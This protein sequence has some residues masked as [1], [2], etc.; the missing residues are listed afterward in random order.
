VGLGLAWIFGEAVGEAVPVLTPGVI[1]SVL[2][3]AGGLTVFA[4]LSALSLRMGGWWRI[5]ALAGLLTALTV[6]V[7]VVLQFFRVEVDGDMRP[8]GLQ[9]RRTSGAI[10]VEA[11]PPTT[12]LQVSASSFPQ[13]LGPQRD[14]QVPWIDLPKRPAEED[15]SVV[16][17]R[18]VGAGWSGF[19]AVDGLAF[20]MEQ[21]GRREMVTAYRLA[22]GKR[23]WFHETI[24]RHD[25]PA[26]GLGPRSTPTFHEGQLFSLGA[27]GNLICFRAH[28]G[29]VLWEKD[30][31]AE[32]GIPVVVSQPDSENRL[33]VEQSN[34]N[35]GRAASPLVVG[36]WVVVPIGGPRGGPQ[37]SLAAFDRATGELQWKAGERA[38]SYGSPALVRLLDQ[39]QIVVTNESDVSSYDP[40]TGRELWSH[41]RPGSSSGAANTS[42]PLAV[43]DNQVLLTKEYG[44]G[45]ELI[46]LSRSPAGQWTTQSVWA[47]PRVLKTKLTVAAVRDHYAYAL[48]A[49]VLECVDWRTGQRTWRGDRFRHGQ[50]LMTQQHLVVLSEDGHLTVVRIDPTEFLPVMTKRQVLSGRCWNT[51]CIVDNLLLARSDREAV[52]IRLPSDTVSPA[53]EQAQDTADKT[54]QQWLSEFETFNAR[55]ERTAALAALDGLLKQH[56][57]ETFAYYQ[58]G[59]LKSWLGDFAGSVADFD[60]YVSLRPEV[61]RRLWERGIAQYFVGQYQAGA[62][63]F[64]LYQTYHDN[65]V[66]NS[67]WRYL[68]QSQTEGVER[69]REQLLPIQNDPRVPLMEIYR[70]FRG[71]GT[72]AEVL[73]AMTAN[74]PSPSELASRKFYGHYYLGLYHESLGQREIA[75]QNLQRAVEV[76]AN[77]PFI[78]RYMWDIAKVHL[79][80]LQSR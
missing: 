3:F 54:P 8:S 46:E 68:C 26:G 56:P 28:S 71:E 23:V 33:D 58:R 30:L 77:S 64:E 27:V 55:G 6:G 12:A 44:L 18:D 52:C 4:L 42:Q 21:H 51:L 69:A 41:P 29:E 7:T 34:L 79:Q 5:G 1:E 74:D 9:L 15:F 66:E 36:D 60:H 17:R 2:T 65:D 25:D 59:C 50:L 39:E 53:V 40:A 13:F 16:W 14:L 67:V 38:I 49:G 61:E 43:A 63:Q 78:S 73:E 10:A 11:E 20:T 24:R 37:V 62:K 35:W 72:E 48:S 19:S 22:D 76:P 75:L 70:L 45:G 57:T 31:T 32:F 80:H 47:N